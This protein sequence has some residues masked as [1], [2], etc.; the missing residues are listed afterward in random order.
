MA[1]EPWNSPGRPPGLSPGLD[2]RSVLRELHDPV[3]ADVVVPVGDE[4]VAVGRYDD[5]ARRRELTRSA[6][7][8]SRSA[9]GHQHLSLRTELD[10]NLTAFVPLR[11]PVGGNGVGHPHVAVAIDIE[12]VRPDEQATAETLHDLAV[13]PELENGIR[14]RVAAFVAEASRI[15]EALTSHDRPDVPAVGVHRHLAD[16]AHRPA[17][18]QLR[19]ALDDAIRVGRDLCDD[20]PPD[21]RDEREDDEDMESHW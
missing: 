3:V 21:A 18:G 15:L 7:G 14:L 16:G 19:P 8:L 4:D 9:Q 1:C 12:P 2:E 10:D 17:V 13:R 6:A 20:R 11:N 5:I